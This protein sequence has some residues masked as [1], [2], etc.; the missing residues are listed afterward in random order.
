MKSNEGEDTIDVGILKQV[1]MVDYGDLKPVL[2]KVSWVKHTRQ[3]QRMIKK[4]R[5]GFWM[6]KLDEREDPIAKN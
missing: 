1:V 3:G 6:Y 5:H 2:M 4:D